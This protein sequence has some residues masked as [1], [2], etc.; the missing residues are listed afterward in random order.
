MRINPLTSLAPTLPSNMVAPS[1]ISSCDSN[2]IS[3]GKLFVEKNE[4][5]LQL[6]KVAFRD[7]FDFK[8]AWS[9]TTRFEAHCCQNHVNGVFEQLEV[10][11]SKMFLG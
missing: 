10:R 7:K 9:T 8:I 1:F 2:D 3:V 6:Y 11:T 4:F 5:I